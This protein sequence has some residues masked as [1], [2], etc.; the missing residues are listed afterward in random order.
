MEG[1]ELVG[2]LANLLMDTMH[3][4]QGQRVHVVGEI[5]NERL[6]GRSRCI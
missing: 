2:E 1:Q 4:P 5:A 3:V 6:E